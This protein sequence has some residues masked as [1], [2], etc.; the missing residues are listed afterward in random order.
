MNPKLEAELERKA[1]E[2]DWLIERYLGEK[3]GSTYVGISSNAMLRQALVSGTK[4][5][6][7]EF[8]HD[9]DDLSRCLMT[10]AS[11]PRHLQERM[12]PTL[13]LY[14]QAVKSWV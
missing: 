9:L 1:A 12:L 6:D 3:R 2:R 4:V 5:S 10:F 11:A 8:P 14:I 7:G 13:E